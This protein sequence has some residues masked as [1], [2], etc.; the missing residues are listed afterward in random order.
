MKDKIDRSIIGALGGLVGG[1][2]FIL[3]LQL[4]GI[5]VKD[6]YPKVIHVAH[7]FVPAGT[8]HTFPGKI[9][10][11][12]AHFTVA[13]LLGILYVNIFRLTGRDWVTT[14]GIIFGAATWVVL[15]G[16]MG[17]LLNL[18]LQSGAASAF[19]ILTTHLLFGVVTSWSIFGLSERVKL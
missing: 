11:H 1:L 18:P 9:I 8:D 2:A 10:A 7:L 3:F 5:Y 16:F 15:Y 17:R 19:V 4:A 6:S 12:I 14:K 13:S